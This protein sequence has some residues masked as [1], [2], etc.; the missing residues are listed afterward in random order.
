M[1]VRKVRSSWSG[2]D[3]FDVF[4]GMLFRGIVNQNVEAP[5]FPDGLLDSSFT[6]S[7]LADISCDGQAAT[8]M[9]GN[10][11]FSLFG[12]LMLIQINHR[13]V[14][15]FLS[16]SD[17]DRAT[18]SAISPRDESNLVFELPRRV[19]VALL[20]PRWGP[21]LRFETRLTV[22]LLLGARQSLV[23]DWHGFQ[24]H[25][26]DYPW[27]P[28]NTCRW[29][30]SLKWPLSIGLLCHYEKIHHPRPIRS[31]TSRQSFRA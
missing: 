19:A 15:S 11:S 18:N 10:Q 4:L 2:T 22:L 27:L 28:Q 24:S 14:R 30:F 9:T 31:F 26:S 1:L 12:V 7:L 5:E 21:H 8:A 25:R 6:K 3:I 16:E 20:R 23:F 29:Q 13:Y 17:S